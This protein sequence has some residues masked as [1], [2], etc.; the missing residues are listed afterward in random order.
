MKFQSILSCVA[1]TALLT[2]C[3]R[4]L[5]EPHN[6]PKVTPAQTTYHARVAAYALNAAL[7]PY[8]NAVLAEGAVAFWN[9]AGMTDISGHEHHGWA[10]TSTTTTLPNGDKC[11]LLNGSGQYAEVNSFAG[12]SV[13]ATGIIT[14]EAWVRPDV[15]DFPDME[16]TGYVNWMGKG[17][18]DRH[19]YV[20]R[21]YGQ[22]PGGSDQGRTNRITGNAF[23]PGGQ[24]V[25]GS[26]YQPAASWAL[27]PGEWMHYV[28]IINTIAISHAYP[29]GYTKLIV[30]RKNNNDSLVVFED[31]DALGPTAMV[32]GT[33]PFR[34]GTRNFGSYFKGGIG[35]IAVYD[36]ELGMS[37]IVEHGK[38]M[39]G[40]DYRVLSEAP[41][42]FWNTAGTD[43]TGRDHPGIVYNHPGITSMPDGDG[44]LVFNG[45]DQYVEVASRPDL[46]VP[47]TG[48]LTLDAWVRADMLTFERMTGSGYVHWMGKR[49]NGQCE[50]VARMYGE[51]PVGYDSGRV[52]RISGYA[53]NLAGDKGTGSYYQAAGGWPVQAG[54]WIHYTL[55]INTVDT[56]S[57]YRTGYTKLYVQRRNAGGVIVS[58]ED[59]DALTDYAV[60]PRA[61]TAPLRIATEDFSSFFHGSIG[62]VALYNYELSA[63]QSLQHARWMFE[64]L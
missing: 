58:F 60:I 17:E 20:C 13:T 22:N 62:K 5:E 21:M 14:L 35:K 26:Y 33:A 30:Q 43:L 6:P 18:S 47:A 64:G 52:N 19:E 25:A 49:E 38:K 2:G 55:I 46:S 44:A 53:F 56:N 3:R 8:D 7:S 23:T 31:Q 34:I 48:I 45:T 1:L 11:L 24:S 63:A 61:G 10:N 29:Y 41:V 54:E 39:F 36:Q 4:N 27:M 28:F 40:Y 16:G 57:T 59:K 42:A 37:T 9:N 12:L 50:Y 15:P 32:A 51:T